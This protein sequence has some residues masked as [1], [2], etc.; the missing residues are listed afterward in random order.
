MINLEDKI[1]SLDIFKKHFTC[2]LKAC[3][4]A[5]CVEGDAGAPI[6]KKE[7]KKIKKIYKKIKP[8]MRRKS[9]EEVQKNGFSVVDFEGDLTTALVEG[10]ECVFVYYEGGIAKCVF[11]KAYLNKEIDFKKPI[12]CHLF[13]IRV[14]K[15]SGFE[16][17]NYEKIKICNSACDN[18]RKIK[19]P[20]YK[21]LKES[22]IRK[23][24]LS[25]YKKLLIAADLIHKKE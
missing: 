3:K 18:G 14:K 9:V 12:S 17:I 6:T 7:Q 19:I 5:C 21:F 10:K 15:Y 16:S 22:L 13:P 2:D 24:G 11:E 25:W 8:Y 1:V 4:G 23:Y 20:L